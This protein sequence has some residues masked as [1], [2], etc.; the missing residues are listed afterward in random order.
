MYIKKKFIIRKKIPIIIQ[1]Y[2][3]KEVIMQ[4]WSN[5]RSFIDTCLKQYSIFF[6]RKRKNKW[7]K[8]EYSKNFQKVI[9]IKIDCDLDSV[10]YLVSQL[11]NKCCHF[12]K[13]SCYENYKKNN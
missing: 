1:N 5:S 10:I 6:S 7:V 12:F 11:N 9:I 4:A 8:G 2:K 13:K 3:N